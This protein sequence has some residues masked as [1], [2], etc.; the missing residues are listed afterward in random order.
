MPIIVNNDSFTVIQFS[1]LCYNIFYKFNFD[2][3]SRMPSNRRKISIKNKSTGERTIHRS[4][5]NHCTIDDDEHEQLP[6]RTRNT[7]NDTL[8]EKTVHA[9]EIRS[10]VSQTRVNKFAIDMAASSTSS[11]LSTQSRETRTTA[12]HA[13]HASRREISSWVNQRGAVIAEKRMYL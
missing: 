11:S 9:R 3:L 6:R 8:R 10:V 2:H 4:Q 7:N 1:I 12:R 5:K 13:S